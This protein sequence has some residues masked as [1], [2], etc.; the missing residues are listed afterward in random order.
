M[1]DFPYELIDVSLSNNKSLKETISMLK[2]ACCEKTINEPLYKI[3]G[4]LVTKLEEKRITNEKFFEYISSIHFQVSA[5]L[6]DDKLSNILDRL[7]DGYYL[8]TQGIYGD[9][10]TIRKEALEELI[11]FKNYK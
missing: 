1:E 2:K 6:I 9:I 8:A 7:D 3:I 4:E 5:L 10:E 11:H